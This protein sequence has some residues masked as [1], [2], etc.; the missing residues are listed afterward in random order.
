MD[1]ESLTATNRAASLEAIFNDN[2]GN[3]LMN[4]LNS[5]KIEV[6]LGE[7]VDKVTILEIRM[8][9]IDDVTKRSNIVAEHQVLD[10]ALRAT[11]LPQSD[12]QSFVAELRRVNEELWEIEDRLREHE[13]DGIFDA[14]FVALARSVYRTNDERAAIKRNINIR[15]NSRLIEEKS[16]QTY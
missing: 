11:R 5:I 12:L 9:R 14:T 15:F 4:L 8:S 7:L 2:N 3:N 10:E 16:Y 6:P 13:R 1:T